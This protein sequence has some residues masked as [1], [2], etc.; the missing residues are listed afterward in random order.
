MKAYSDSFS[1]T[2]FLTRFEVVRTLSKVRIEC[3][4]LASTSLFSLYMTK[5]I[6]VEEFE[7]MQT[8]SLQNV[9]GSL[10]D[11]WINVVKNII[12]NGFKDVGKGW[13][14]IFESNLEVYKISKLRKFM[15]TVKFVMQ[16]SIRTMVISSINDFTR[17]I[18]AVSSQKVAIF[19][20]NN[21]KVT[22][23]IRN[24]REGMSRKPLFLTDIVF[25]ASRLQYNV[26]FES[27]EVGLLAL[28]D[29]AIA[30]TDNLPQLEPLVLDQ[31][32]WAAKP[33]LQTVNRRE[34]AVSKIRKAL[35]LAI[36][37]GI[38]P[39]EEYL[40]HYSKHLKL[41]NL[42]IAQFS[43]KYEAENHSNHEMVADIV[44]FAKEWE[45]L[46]KEIPSHI[47]LG[48]FWV[49]CDT[50]RSSM[51]KDVSKVI[52]E[53]LSR[54]A[55]KFAA[56]A[57]SGFA[58]IYNRLKEPPTKIEELIELREYVGSINESLKKAQ[59]FLDE[60]LDQYEILDN[61]KFEISNEEMRA[62]WTAFAWPA[63][64]ADL[65]VQTEISM[66][67][68]EINFAKNLQVD[69]EVFKDRINNLTASITEFAKFSD[70]TRIG[71]IVGE[72]NKVLDGLK[73]VQALV[74]L[75][76]SREKLF[77]LEPTRY[78]EVPQ[79]VRDFEPFKTFWITAGDWSKWK[80][81][82]MCGSFLELNAEEVERNLSNAWKN[83]FKSL[84]SFKNAPGPLEAAGLV[85]CQ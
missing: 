64:I 58:T 20:S 38:A 54:K 21:V 77:N 53:I 3:D 15:T 9:K 39:L 80:D 82:W 67:A 72:V 61:H 41:L 30:T 73:E 28:F 84:K 25:K 51:K 11:S 27:L 83:V 29:K 23:G 12:K 68:D 17:A 70:L 69:Q 35:V 52:L 75:F 10:K 62:R 78:D 13:Y 48:L 16:D 7:Q 63:K 18:A 2:S 36:Q 24:G 65:M 59:A 42:D 60:M 45:V 71:D 26:D 85:L 34:S 55:S 46:D 33:I 5:T 81:Q 76:N 74:L 66:A 4:R 8:Q 79:L 47:N 56:S 1:F 43:A 50:I 49:G 19:G 57:S 6:K 14:N 44:K 40:T 37:Q 22:D 31:M 32:F